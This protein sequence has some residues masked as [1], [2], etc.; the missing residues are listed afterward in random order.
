[1]N[2]QNTVT[3]KYDR[4]VKMSKAESAS[5]AEEAH[6]LCHKISEELHLQ[7][8]EYVNEIFLNDFVREFNAISEKE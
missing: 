4:L 7:H 5:L 1:M 3:D 6:K 2:D 8:T